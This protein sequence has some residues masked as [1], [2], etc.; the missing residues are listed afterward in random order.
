MAKGNGL[1]RVQTPI[2]VARQIFEIIKRKKTHGYV[3]K[4]WRLIAWLL[5]IMP[6]ALY[7]RL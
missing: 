7:N 5:K 4:R 1:F 6:D 2:K 3:T